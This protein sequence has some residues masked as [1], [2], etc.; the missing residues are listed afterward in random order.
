MNSPPTSPYA[1]FNLRK[2]PFGSVRL[3]D[4][5]SLIVADLKPLI[6]HLKQERAA[7]QFYGDCGRGKST[8]LRALHSYFSEAPY[9]YIG[10]GEKPDIPFEPLL[11]LDETQRI[12]WWRRARIFR[13][14]CSIALATHK[15]HTRQLQR[16]GYEVLTIEV[17]GLEWE[18]L[19]QVVHNRL[20]WARLGEGELPSIPDEVLRSFF[21]LYGDDLR[22]IERALYE[23]IQTLMT[24]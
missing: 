11:F 12:P 4:W 5:R 20:E 16:Q 9:I 21:D 2:N 7:I 14:I 10:E 19:K 6:A 23:Y 22:S 1:A 17:G 24:K 3:K 18:K 13:N 8:H 15:L